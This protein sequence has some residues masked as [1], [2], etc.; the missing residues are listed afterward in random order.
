MSASIAIDRA[1]A[2]AVQLFS[3]AW[4]EVVS[5]CP[6]AV[7]AL[8]VRR[9]AT[10]IT[11]DGQGAAGGSGGAACSIL[12]RW[13][14]DSR[15]GAGEVIVLLDPARVLRRTVRLSALAARDP[16]AAARLQAAT[17]SPIRPEDA[18]LSVGAAR[19]RPVTGQACVDLAIARRADVDAAAA[20]AAEHGARWRIAGEFD[21][22]GPGFV[23]ASHTPQRAASPVLM[24]ALAAL[25]V[26][27]AITA[28]DMRLS[29]DFIALS[30]ERE[31]LLD[32][33]RA[34][35]LAEAGRAEGDTPAGRAARYPLLA[36]VLT[37]AAAA[38][39]EALERV[40]A[41]GRRV[42]VETA[43]GQVDESEAGR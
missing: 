30:A 4:R 15:R 32:E 5:L 42:I 41:V 16:D 33:A 40:R 9:R 36:D 29:R 43:D 18:A 37:Q 1:G 19:R 22:E 24:I 38:D 11:L 17:L 34:R 2:A 25:A 23:F 39:G 31:A 14:H 26:L 12:G 21:A 28:L 27:A 10:L 20:L 7:A 35:R 3:R 8:G 13:R 6:P